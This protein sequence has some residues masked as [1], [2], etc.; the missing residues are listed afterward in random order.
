[1]EKDVTIEANK[2]FQLSYNTESVEKDVEVIGPRDLVCGVN[3]KK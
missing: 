3:T 1:M 2:G